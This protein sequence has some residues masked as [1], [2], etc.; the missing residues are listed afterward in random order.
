MK[1]Q[2][3]I[4]DRFRFCTLCE[5]AYD[6]KVELKFYSNSKSAF[7]NFVNVVNARSK[8]SIVY[9]AFI[10]PNCSNFYTPCGTIKK[11]EEEIDTD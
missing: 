5:E 9:V 3:F 2:V 7:V 4:M 11:Y 6:K 1:S 8:N 10:C